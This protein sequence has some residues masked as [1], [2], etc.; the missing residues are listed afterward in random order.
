MITPIDTGW[1]LPFGLL[2]PNGDRVKKIIKLMN[3]YL[4]FPAQEENLYSTKKHHIF[5]VNET[6][7]PINLSQL[8]HQYGT[9][10]VHVCSCLHCVL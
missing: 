6:F 4:Y 7:L 9:I 8:T 1:D 2:Q 5:S 3:L 10:P